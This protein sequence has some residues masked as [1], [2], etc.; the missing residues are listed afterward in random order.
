ME[1]FKMDVMVVQT[2][3]HTVAIPL[4]FYPIETALR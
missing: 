4:I 3:S 1:W 2:S